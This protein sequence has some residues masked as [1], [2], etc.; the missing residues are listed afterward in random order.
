MNEKKIEQVYKNKNK[1]E[2]KN[3]Y[4]KNIQKHTER[5]KINLF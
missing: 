5:T 2:Y 3:E 4:K 1:K